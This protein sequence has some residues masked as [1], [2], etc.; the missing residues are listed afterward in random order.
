MK[1]DSVLTDLPFFPGSYQLR[2]LAGF[3]PGF[4]TTKIVNRYFDLFCRENAQEQKG[5]N[6]CI[7]S[8]LS[9]KKGV[10]SPV[11]PSRF[12]GDREFFAS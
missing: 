8:N 5:F 7:P 6:P 9:K 2:T 1:P 12:T 11:A 4:R 10:H 3:A